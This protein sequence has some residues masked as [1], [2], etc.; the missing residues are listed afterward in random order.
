MIDLKEL[1]SRFPHHKVISQPAEGCRCKGTGVRHHPKFGD[2]CCICVCVS[3]PAPGE[4]E[5]RV[6]LGNA[7]SRAAKSALNDYKR[8][9]EKP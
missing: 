5:Y 4:P 3:P 9:I 6:E 1:Q 7:L 8:L 2:R